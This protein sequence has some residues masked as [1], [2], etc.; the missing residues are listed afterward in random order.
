MTSGFSSFWNIK[1]TTWL[2]FLIA[3]L[4]LSNAFAQDPFIP[5]YD[6][7]KRSERCF[8][9]TY[10]QGNQFGA[11]WFRDKG[12]FSQDTAL[13]FVMYFGHKNSDGADG[14]AFVMHND[15]RDINVDPSQTVDIGGG[16][17]FDLEAATGDDGGGLGYALHNSRVNNN[18]IDGPHPDG[19]GT[20]W[21]D[22]H[23]IWPSVAI[24]FDTYYNGDVQ[25]GAN[26]SGAPPASPYSGQDHTSVVYDGDLYNQQQEIWG[27]DQNGN[28]FQ[29]R[30]QPIL[31]IEGWGWNKDAED[32]NCYAFKINWIVN[33]DG[34]QTLELWADNYDPDILDA[35]DYN[36]YQVMTH[37]DDMINGVFDGIT[38]LRFG[39]TG[40]TGGL[41]NEQTICLLGGNS[42]PTALD[43]F[44][45]TPVNTPVTVDVES[46]DN[47][48][49]GDNLF[50][51]TIV[52]QADNGFAEVISVGDDNFIRYTPNTNFVGTDTIRY[53][54]C[55][56][57]SDKC[58][59]LCDEANVIITVGCETI[60]IGANPLTPYAL[61]DPNL[62][63]NGSAE[64]FFVSG[65]I[66]GNVWVE[67]FA[68]LNGN[69]ADT[70]T[71]AWAF[72]TDGTCNN[73]GD[74]ID[75][76]NER[77]RAENTG[78]EVIW[79][80]EDIDISTVTDVGISI[81]LEAA[82]DMES[83]DFLE[84]YY[85]L[86]GGAETPLTNGSFTDNFG[87]STAT[88]SAIN[89]NSLRIK[90]YAQNS[91]SG[92]RYSWDDIY[93]TGTGAGAPPSL[94]YNWFEGSVL[95]ANSIGT[96][97]VQSGLRDTT[98]YVFATNPSTGC[99][100]DTVSVT[101]S[102]QPEV[103]DSIYTLQTS[104][105]TT[106]LPP[107]DGSLAAGVIVDGDSITSGYTFEWRYLTDPGAA[108]IRV[109]ANATNLEASE[110]IVTAINQATGCFATK[111]DSVTNEVRTPEVFPSVIND[112]Y[113]C[114]AVNGSVTAT[115][116]K[117]GIPLNS[118][119]GYFW[120][121][122]L[123][124]DITTPAD[125]VGQTIIDLAPGNYSVIVID[126]ST[127]CTSESQNVNVA[128]LRQLPQPIITNATDQISCDPS[129]PTGSFTSAVDNLSGGT[130]TS[131]FTFNWY[132][133]LNDVTPARP[134]YTGGP[135]VD[136]LPEDIY[137]LIVVNDTSGCEAILDTAIVENLVTPTIDTAVTTPVNI[138]GPNPNGTITVTPNGNV[139][140]FDYRL[141]AGNGVVPANLITETSSNFFD[142]LDIGTYTVT[143]VDAITNCE[144]LGRV[145]N[146]TDMTVIPLADFEVF[147][148]YAC[149]PAPPTGRIEATV[150]VGSPADYTFEWF[151]NDTS[152]APV[153]STRGVNGEI[154][155]TL[156]VGTYALLL[157]N[158]STNCQN[159][160]FQNIGQS[161]T[162]PVVDTAYSAPSTFCGPNGNG[163]LH[164]AADAGSTD[165]SIFTFNWTDL[166]SGS[167]ISTLADVNNLVPGDYELV[168]V[169]DT[170][171]CRSNPYPVT[172]DD[173]SITPDAIIAATDNSS[174]D[175]NNPNGQLEVS[176]VTNE[177]VYDPTNYS[178]EWYVGNS[179]GTQL[180]TPNVSFP[181][182]PD[183]SLVFGLAEETY[184]LVITNNT[185][186]CSNEVLAQI[187]DTNIKPVLDY[188][189]IIDAVR[190][191]DP[192]MSGVEI[193]T[194]N[195][196]QPIPAG[197]SFELE[198]IGT[199]DIY[200]NT[201]GIF[202]DLTNADGII[203]PPGDYRII[204]LNSFNC[205]SD[206]IEF[207]IDDDS[208]DPVFDLTS[209]NNS[210]C[211]MTLPNGIVVA[212]TDGSYG[213]NQIEW[214]ITNTSGSPV[215]PTI[216]TAAI[217][218]DDSVATGLS[219]NTYA[220]RLTDENGC[221]STEFASVLDIPGNDPI[222]DSLYAENLTSCVIDDGLIGLGVSP[223]EQLPPDLI[224][225]RT[226]TFTIDNSGTIFSRSTNPVTHPDTVNFVGL[227]DGDW[228][229]TVTDDF[230]HCTSDPITV[231]L[232]TAPEIFFNVNVT[233]IVSCG[234]VDG[235]IE[236]EAESPGFNE[237]PGGDGFT[238]EWHDGNLISDPILST[239]TIDDDWQTTANSL[240]SKFYTV[241]VTDNFS[242][243]SKDTSIFVQS[244]SVPL[245]QGLTSTDATN[246]SPSNGSASVD[247]DPFSFPVGNSYSDYDFKIYEGLSFD[248]SDTPYRVI[249]NPV[250]GPVNF[251]ADLELGTYIVVAQEDFVG[252]GGCYTDPLPFT[253]GLDFDLE[254]N[255]FVVV[256]DSS[257][258]G[259]IA[260]GEL[261]ASFNDFTYNVTQV[262]YAW[263]QGN[264]TTVPEEDPL[265][266]DPATISGK[267]AG[268]FTVELTVTGGDGL[269]CVYSEPINLPKIQPAMAINASLVDNLNCIGHNGEVSLVDI[270]IDGSN[271]N[272]NNFENF[273]IDDENGN[274]ISVVPNTATNW[275]NLSPGDYFL[276]ARKI[277]TQCYTAIRKVTIDDD[278]QT[279]ILNITMD[280]PDFS[281]ND[282]S[283]TGQLTA[284][285]TPVP[286]GAYTWQ[287]TNSLGGLVASTDTPPNTS[288]VSNIQDDKYT[289]IVTDNDG[290]GINDG[291]STTRDFTLTQGSISIVTPLV[292]HTDQTICDENASITVDEI[293]EIRNGTIFYT[294]SPPP[295]PGTGYFDLI[296]ELYDQN[297]TA[298][299]TGTN[300]WAAFQS[301]DGR[302][303]PTN[304]IPVGT[305]YV[306][307]RNISTGC[308]FGPPTQVIVKN[309]SKKPTINIT[310]D[311][312]DY[313]CSDMA[314][315]TG[316]LSAIVYGGSDLD[317]LQT[318]FTFEWTDDLGNPIVGTT[319]ITTLSEGI[320]NLKVTDNTSLDE[321][322]ERT[323]SFEVTHELQEIIIVD[324][325]GTDNT[326]C[327]PGNGQFWVNGLLVNGTL[328]D[329]ISDP[330]A[331]SNYS[332][333]MFVGNLSTPLGPMYNTGLYD[334]PIDSLH[335]N[336]LYAIAKNNITLCESY[337]RQ[338]IVND[339]SEDP[340]ISMTKLSDNYSL[341]Y[342]NINSLTGE[343]EAES[344]EA[345][346]M[347]K[348]PLGYS[349][350]WY[351][352]EIVGD[353]L[354]AEANATNAVQTH[355]YLRDA[356]YF[357]E[358]TDSL[359][360]CV[361]TAALNL[362]FVYLKP[363]FNPVPVA[364]THCDP[365]NGSI[366]IPSIYKVSDSTETFTKYEFD[367]H[368]G[369][370]NPGNPFFQEYGG[371]GGNAVNGL[372][373][374]KYYVHALD[375]F[376]MVQSDP[377]QVE[378]EDSTV[379]PMIA[380]NGSLSDDQTSCNPNDP[381]GALGVNV[382]GFDP[383]SYSWYEGQTA[384]GTPIGSTNQIIQQNAGFYTI[385]VTNQTTGCQSLRTFE[386]RDNMKIPVVAA[387]MSPVTNCLPDLANG[388][389]TATITNIIN[390]N[391]DFYWYEGMSESGTPVYTDLA[392]AFDSEKI[393]SAYYDIPGGFYT[394]VARD[395]FDCRSDAVTIEV[396]EDLT[397]PKIAVN[398]LSPLTY[399]DPDRPNAVMSATANGQVA[400]Y[401]FNWNIKNGP[402]YT[403]GPIVNNLNDQL[404]TLVVINN[405]TGCR[406]FRDVQPTVAY[407]NVPEPIVDVL[408]EMSSCISPNGRAT[409]TIL[410]QLEDYSFHYLHPNGFNPMTDNINGTTISELDINDYF[411]YAKDR[412]SGCISDTVMFVINDTR[413]VPDYDI[414]TEPSICNEATGEAEVIIGDLTRPFEVRWYDDY[415]S[416]GTG[417]SINY[418]PAGQYYVAVEG[419]EGC[420]DST[421]TFIGTDIII[422]NA[423]SNN[424]D[425]LNEAF[426][427]E[428]IDIFPDN[429]VKIFNRAGELVY[430]INDYDS[431][432]PDRSFTGFSNR[433]P[434]NGNQ[435]A[436]G[437][438]YYVVDLQDGTK[439]RVGFL[440][441]KR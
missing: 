219:G 52:Q 317:A 236:L 119:V 20:T 114:V 145:V 424:Y 390:S 201:T 264:G 216:P 53:R 120:Y 329:H 203:L 364:Q 405:T 222:I 413:Y 98:Y 58:Y 377:V 221:A 193:T 241:R 243:C 213:V 210:S 322:C 293:R 122:G 154:L 13:Y 171:Q 113:S 438:Y 379:Y 310:M 208:T 34:T 162:L 237:R 376:W 387:S 139:A 103:V 258:T 252:S 4:N 90:I 344:F 440:E 33:N 190:C 143:I 137:R 189:T 184:A 135:N 72:T 59:A 47:D 352:N 320:Y 278:S 138:C 60:E 118:G 167:V 307:S 19:S 270:S 160:Y 373:A 186:N 169:N 83:S 49:D 340:L 92:E 212:S 156:A 42:R 337:P 417:R 287:W 341:N 358:V 256:S 178:F 356:Q 56:V 297:L 415:E 370:Y 383:Y 31:P 300:P 269:G 267:N 69:T 266:G 299:N 36:Y 244:F 334:D 410:G 209:Y 386:I 277:T 328:I 126:S 400:G 8:T 363:K 96:G 179:S 86:D 17:N 228:I 183:S 315:P 385:L 73:S 65:T 91:A 223:L 125:Y 106:C 67:T 100:S 84:V 381:N 338:V 124:A 305:Y 3:F 133:G 204:A 411:V 302:F 350:K 168:I 339:R 80:T 433:G 10:D 205:A 77:F 226:Y 362:P 343:L 50:V 173:E 18:T 38:D 369:T 404:Y 416:Y 347:G 342:D 142:M 407:V 283:P 414:I 191:T 248:A 64:A 108:P 367:W 355:E 324:A 182:T 330:V 79:E 276:S 172:V 391:Y 234:D 422:Y 147:P 161:I 94:T 336:T 268:T 303:G 232:E 326:W 105:F 245:L 359:T 441:L 25:D 164:A 1:I 318:N 311:S 229:A 149:T 195:G 301:V 181:N 99:N 75:V 375:T 196:G 57:D 309:V 439:P 227:A 45:S 155:D 289:V 250:S 294:E 389:A 388:I 399:C 431:E 291:C 131:G 368:S 81:F 306:K 218:R 357:V 35:E 107:Y 200:S 16:G 55:D 217:V 88:A 420:I 2:I 366:N 165:P 235:S 89:G 215:V 346:G 151:V 321:F 265:N 180:V 327:E 421:T 253:I 22:N 292:S 354:F 332:V 282:I 240:E 220:V 437:T 361:S 37:T 271:F 61:C 314:T 51:P 263:Y 295:L 396:L 345:D 152:G 284:I 316:E 402:L 288:V 335:E 211:D 62:T 254:L 44:A 129:N 15:P 140:D 148:Q 333:D 146:I 102:S 274:E 27:Y 116:Q 323:V 382:P 87:S 123:I 177:G 434:I 255:P 349:Y 423:V 272:L 185:T 257:C 101:I 435:L 115:A 378:V 175:V 68:G 21:R 225:N 419:T 117:E 39:F 127:M 308:N 230:T 128:D 78:C 144:S 9:I 40:S 312:P 395:T 214:F 408:D 351:R 401:T 111:T 426:Y 275:L 187:I 74:D 30:L 121:N 319:N 392:G 428:C 48:F 394:V 374:G 353:S 141:Y 436:I 261:D 348:S 242:L 70:G 130:M 393:N 238:F 202:E 82:G 188:P 93:V 46:N 95:P 166:G 150:T 360:G 384:S 109:G 296:A 163:E 251:A 104:P 325:D 11:V 110:Y 273:V 32:N 43:D 313:S 12:D 286:G 157:T 23:R 198:N 224:D 397:Y 132:R 7:V 136:Q 158:N 372:T 409:S 24:E 66:V 192:Y 153:T 281:C 170:T 365:P 71:T 403:S 371:N 197:Y 290:D 41:N 231:T 331:F 425:G 199:G 279:P 26:N 246:C 63:P 304:E 233:P 432:D 259:G 249:E 412:T 207:A 247:V 206:T 134:G 112:V 418:K 285:A 260:T 97:A 406:S 430:E 280:S 14:F 194:V 174:C 398:E 76:D 6:A 427:I 159:V 29:N 176:N 298:I 28:L 85:I 429:N 239:V 380:Y 54:T 5:K 262:D